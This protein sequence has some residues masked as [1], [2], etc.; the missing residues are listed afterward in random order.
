MQPYRGN[1]LVTDGHHN[2]V[3]CTFK[4]DGDVSEVIAFPNIVPTGLELL[5]SLVFVAQAGPVP[6]LPQ[7]GRIVALGPLAEGSIQVAAGARLLVDVESGPHHTLYGL[8]QGFSP[9]EIPRAPRRI[10]IPVPS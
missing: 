6:H 8:A 2:R 9:P 10:R 4:R 1:F 5:G 3:L 7:N